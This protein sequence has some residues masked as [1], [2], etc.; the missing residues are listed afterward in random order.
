MINPYRDLPKPEGKRWGATWKVR[1]LRKLRMIG[2]YC[3]C[4]N[5][6]RRNKDLWYGG[7]SE[8]WYCNFAHPDVREGRP[9]SKYGPGPL[10]LIQIFLLLLPGLL[11]GLAMWIGR[12]AS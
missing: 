4:C 3:K 5:K 8:T 6:F 2:G 9:A 12:K 1:L 10:V 11:I 7:W